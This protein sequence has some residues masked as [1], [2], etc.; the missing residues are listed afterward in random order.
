[1]LPTSLLVLT[2]SVFAPLIAATTPSC[3]TGATGYAS[4]K[5]PYLATNFCSELST[6]NFGNKQKYYDA[7]TVMSMS[8]TV[9]SAAECSLATC[10]TSFQSL[11]D[12]CKCSTVAKMR[13]NYTNTKSGGKEDKSIWGTGSV[14]CSCGT[15]AFSVYAP[16][17]T[18]TL[19]NPDATITV[20]TMKTYDIA[21]LTASTSTST[22]TSSTSTSSSST[23]TSTSSTP[24][25]SSY[26]A[27]TTSSSS[28]TSSTYAPTTYTYANLTSSTTYSY[29]ASTGYPSSGTLLT[30]TTGTG[31]PII[32]A[33]Y[34]PSAAPT[35]N[36]SDAGMLRAGGLG[37]VVLAS[38]FS[39]FL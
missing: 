27:T 6:A 28:T 7:P 1:M 22:S 9:A 3:T 8:F 18:G 39:V 16:S 24:S 13:M 34:T 5:L 15:F 33:T 31:S 12:S 26:P 36:S 21:S 19:G 4:Q 10:L 11:V 20:A 32:S 35:P 38:F 2:T 17:A 14:D 37:L 30:S 25:P 23:S 29:V